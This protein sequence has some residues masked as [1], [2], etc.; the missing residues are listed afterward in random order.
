MKLRNSLLAIVFIA[1][2]TIAAIA[3][4]ANT[5]TIK[6]SI[7]HINNKMQVNDVSEMKSL[8][9]PDDERTFIP[10]S[11]GKFSVSFK[12]AQPNYFK[13]GRNV[14][15]LS[16]GDQ[17]TV[18]LDYNKP[19]AAV[20]TGKGADANNYLRATPFPHG[21]SYLEAGKNIKKTIALTIDTILAISKVY[22]QNLAK[23]VN[24]SPK[25][26][27][28]EQARIKADILNSM[29]MTRDYYP[30]KMKLVDDARKAADED[31]KRQTAPYIA[32]YSKGF[33]NP[34]YLKLEVYAGIAGDILDKNDKS[35][36]AMQVKDW[37]NAEDVAY[38][39]Q[40][41][42]SKDEVIAMKPQVD[43]IVNPQYRA[44]VTKTYS[45]LVKFGNGDKAIDFTMTTADNK[46][47]HLSDYTG[48]IIFVD[49]WATWCGPCIAELP[50]MVKLKEKY[51]GNPSVVF[52]SLSI[53]DDRAAW[54]KMLANIKADGIQGVADR[55]SLND[56]SVIDIPRT[57]I[58]NKNFKVA[59]M[60]G[61]LP[62]AKQTAVLLD[63]LL[64]GAA[65]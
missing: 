2:G 21:G 5:V 39:I 3:Q 62:S 17:L 58:I 1:F 45:S 8:Q 47:I 38:K 55:S 6:G 15:Y 26:R 13:I 27:E 53:D 14:L 10:D 65:K 30:M 18:A 20:I 57:I 11:T 7:I 9:L 23:V 16:P 37:L 31:I 64:A 40:H 24:V 52:I 46:K 25:F 43:A 33:T 63:N 41:M 19:E 61:N 35:P 22:E 50:Y 54:K 60:K 49:L 12:L 44:V 29:E 32:Q 51:K 59:A 28:Y 34:D 36:A 48:K 42:G 56:Y 4:T